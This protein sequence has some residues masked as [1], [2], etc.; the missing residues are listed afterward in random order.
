MTTYLAK[1]LGVALG[2]VLLLG[3]QSAA[4]EDY[5]VGLDFLDTELDRLIRCEYRPQALGVVLYL[6]RAGRIDIEKSEWVMAD[7]ESCWRVTPS[8]SFRGEDFFAICVTT[9][10][11]EL[12]K[13]FPKL[14]WRGPGTAPPDRFALLSQRSHADLSKWARKSL[15]MGNYR[16]E[17]NRSTFKYKPG[18]SELA[19]TVL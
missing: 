13:L 17:A 9:G 10:D 16:V 15:P 6:Q 4:S 18:L 8:L 11:P 3:G 2:L 14:Y 7:G 19:C 5:K 1:C 12:V